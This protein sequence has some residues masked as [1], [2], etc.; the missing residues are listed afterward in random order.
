MLTVTLDADLQQ[1]FA[2][3]HAPAIVK[4]ANGKELGTF[5]PVGINAVV[6]PISKEELDRR[7]AEPGGR[8]TKEVLDELKRKYGE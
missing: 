1:V 7:A 5:F 8:T 6:C 2:D 4:D 3:V